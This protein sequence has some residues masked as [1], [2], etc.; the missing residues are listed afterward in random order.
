MKSKNKA[1]QLKKETIGS[2]G[3][4]HQTIGGRNKQTKPWECSL[5]QPN[6]ISDCRP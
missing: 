5:V 1:F 6:G 4:L 3:S 2:L